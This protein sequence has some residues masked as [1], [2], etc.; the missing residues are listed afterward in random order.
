MKLGVRSMIESKFKDD[1][2][3]PVEEPAL[4]TGVEGPVG[5]RAVPSPA[6]CHVSR[7]GMWWQYAVYSFQIADE[8]IGTEGGG[9]KR[10]IQS[11]LVNQR[12]DPSLLDSNNLCF[13]HILLL[14]PTQEP[15][16]LCQ[17]FTLCCGPDKRTSSLSLLIT[18]G[19]SS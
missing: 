8:D 7:R 3:L 15:H 19:L 1:K 2:E 6:V 14:M 11:C 17:S 4:C 5:R 16:S 10:F 9:Q 13:Q 12:P 18:A